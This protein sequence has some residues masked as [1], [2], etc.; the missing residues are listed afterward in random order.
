MKNNLW[1]ISQS[2]TPPTSKD[3]STD[4]IINPKLMPIDKTNFCRISGNQEIN[5]DGEQPL[6]L[7]K[8]KVGKISHSFEY[9]MTKKNNDNNIFISDGGLKLKNQKYK[10]KYN[11]IYTK[12]NNEQFQEEIKTILSKYALAYDKSTYKNNTINVKGDG[13]FDEN[14]FYRTVKGYSNRPMIKKKFSNNNKSHEIHKDQIKIKKN[15]KKFEES[16]QNEENKDD[17]KKNLINGGKKNIDLILKLIKKKRLLKNKTVEKKKEFLQKNG[18]GVSDVNLNDFEEEKK[19][20]DKDDFKKMSKTANHFHRKINNFVKNSQGIPFEKKNISITLESDNYKIKDNQNKKPFKPIVDQ[21]EFIKKI[22][23]EHKIIHTQENNMKN[24]KD[25]IL[26]K[27]K[28]KNNKLNDSFRHQ[29]HN[30]SNKLIKSKE[31]EKEKESLSR[32]KKKELPSSLIDVINDEWPYSHK[33]SYRSPKELN[34][35]KKEKRVLKREKANIEELEKNTKLFNKFK[36]LANLNYKKGTKYNFNINTN[37]DKEKN[38]NI[39]KIPI[40]KSLDINKTSR[41]AKVRKHHFPSKKGK[42]PNEYY[43]GNNSIINNSNSTL[44]EI[45]KYYLNVLESQKLLVDSGFNKKNFNEETK[46]ISDNDEGFEKNMLV[47]SK[48]KINKYIKKKNLN[49]NEIK[50]TRNKEVKINNFIKNKDKIHNKKTKNS[51]KI[52]NSK[53]VFKLVEVIKFIIQRKVYVILYKYYIDLA[54]YQHYSI[55]IFLFY[56]NMQ[57]LSFQ[58]NSLFLDL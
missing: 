23:K 53:N 46:D 8:K 26:L 50:S 6:I 16:K 36:N 32:K 29:S 19:Q 56:C 54:I 21:F 58:K 4:L 10:T 1:V 2:N 38:I 17:L 7:Y 39:E 3:K 31:K 48:D 15:L 34:K 14:V 49:K 47:N 9:K 37:K 44:I 24:Q 11:Y 45:N 52:I 33:R 40:S 25:K 35:F 30:N 13:N 41:S 20:P 43:I 55:C 51:K 28:S 12:N 18:I 5:T 57:K 42:E 27:I 22:N